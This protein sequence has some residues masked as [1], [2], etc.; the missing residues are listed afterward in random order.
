MKKH[1]PNKTES[2][3]PAHNE[4]A[5]RMLL[6][7]A[8]H[9]P[10]I[11]S[12]VQP[13]AF[14]QTWAKDVFAKLAQFRFDKR[15]SLSDPVQLEHDLML[16]LDR[17]TFGELNGALN[18]LPSVHNWPYWLEIVTD[19]ERARAV[20]SL[21]AVARNAADQ[22]IHGEN[23]GLLAVQKR[24]NDLVSGGTAKGITTMKEICRTVINEIDE[25]FANES[26]IKGIPTGLIPL[27]RA[28]NGFEKKKLYVIAARPSQGKSTLLLQFAH[29]AAS[30]GKSVLFFSLEM[31]K[32][33][34][35]ERAASNLSRVPLSN[36]RTKTATPEDF[37]NFTGA[38]SNLSALSMSIV[39]NASSLSDIVGISH[40]TEG[41]QLV[42]VDYLQRLR[43]PHFKG[44][45]N[46]LVTEISVALKDV[47]MMLDVPVIAAAQL[48]RESEKANRPPTLADLRD[49]GAI[50]QDADF[51][52]FLHP[53]KTKEQTD[54]ILGKNRSGDS[55]L[56]IPLLF[57]REIFRFE[58][59]L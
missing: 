40:Q 43:I 12:M 21:G 38:M 52:A 41:V 3:L 49:S 29:A 17:Q 30:S 58:S 24:V 44:N 9:K 34:I 14:Y 33:E 32:E 13:S 37:R 11:I 22:L 57:R 51:V 20:G 4:M 54:L 25:A 8:V 48:N 28:M 39:D 55:N 26:T 19:F 47:S 27:N 7:C 59:V 35:V 45:R 23:S 36:F 31:P 6:A 46:E 5:E 1:P 18:D 2:E 50:E 56:I 16:A 10:D 53:G 15:P 42:V